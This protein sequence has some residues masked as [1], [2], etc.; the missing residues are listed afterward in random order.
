MRPDLTTMNVDGHMTCICMLTTLD[1]MMLKKSCPT[2]ISQHVA[3]NLAQWFA[4]L[5]RRSKSDSVWVATLVPQYWEDEKDIRQGELAVVAEL[6][7]SRPLSDAER[8]AMQG[9]YNQTHGGKDRNLSS[10]LTQSAFW[11]ILRASSFQPVAS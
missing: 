10:S 4:S 7:H 2:F 1:N 5:A 6:G 11:P 3:A 8:R 9:Q